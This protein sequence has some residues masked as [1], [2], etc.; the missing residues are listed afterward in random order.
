MNMPAVDRITSAFS[1]VYSDYFG[2]IY[3]VVY[4]KINNADETEDICQEVFTRL[5]ERFAEVEN[6]RTWLYGAVRLVMLEH[7]RKKKGNDVNVDDL[8]DDVSM[9]YVNGFRDSRIIIGQALEDMN[10]YE[11][12]SERI[13]FELIAIHNFTYKEAAVQLGIT[14]HKLRYKYNRATERLMQYFREKGIKGLEDLL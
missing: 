5:Y 1:I 6:P 9:S 11:D 7:F 3:S 2:L 13:I 4:A 14:E 12:D 10:N 8:L